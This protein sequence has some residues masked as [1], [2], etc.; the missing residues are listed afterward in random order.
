MYFDCQE[1][2]SVGCRH[3]HMQLTVTHALRLD[4]DVDECTGESLKQ[5][6]SRGVTGGLAVLLV[7]P[8]GLLSEC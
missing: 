5:L 3:E 1:P 7:L 4:H 8:N 6:D 2:F